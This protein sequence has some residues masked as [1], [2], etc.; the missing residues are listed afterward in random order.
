MAGSFVA[1]SNEFEYADIVLPCFSLPTSAR[2]M[3]FVMFCYFA[4]RIPLVV[5]YS[6]IMPL[7]SFVLEVG[8]VADESGPPSP[9]IPFA[10]GLTDAGASSGYGLIR[11]VYSV[12]HLMTQVCSLVIVQ[13]GFFQLSVSA[14]DPAQIK[15]C[16]S[17]A[18]PS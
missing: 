14:D 13:H 16:N 12:L 11:E 4:V 1:S 18:V 8:H 9:A 7:Q 10:S 6:L 2:C 17:I 5:V 15:C 3:L